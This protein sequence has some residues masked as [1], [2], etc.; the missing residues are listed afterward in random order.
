MPQAPSDRKA[1]HT[2]SLQA[3]RLHRLQCPPFCAE[4]ER[5][6]L[7]SH[8]GF[9]SESAFSMPTA[10]PA[11]NLTSVASKSTP[12]YAH[13]HPSRP[14]SACLKTFLPDLIHGVSFS[15]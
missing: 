4:Q 11:A 9:P 14:L 3:N 7:T 5:E 6:R 15:A 13:T 10:D 12:T 8:E 1:V 2:F